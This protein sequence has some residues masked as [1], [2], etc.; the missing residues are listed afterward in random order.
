MGRL[1][2]PQPGQWR[3]CHEPCCGE[4]ASLY[5]IN[6]DLYVWSCPSGNHPDGVDRRPHAVRDQPFHFEWPI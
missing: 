1:G 6:G 5:F 2:S 3:P 4:R